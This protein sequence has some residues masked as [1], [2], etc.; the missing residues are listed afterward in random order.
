MVIQLNQRYASCDNSFAMPKYSSGYHVSIWGQMVLT[1]VISLKVVFRKVLSYTT[2]P[3]IYKFF[4]LKVKIS[5][6]SIYSHIS[7]ILP[8]MDF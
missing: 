1:H 4:L 2:S 8:Y 3:H 5:I 7:Q 6:H